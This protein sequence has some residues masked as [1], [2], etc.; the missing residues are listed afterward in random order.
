[1]VWPPRPVAL[2]VEGLF[3]G[4]HVAEDALARRVV[5]VGE[6][7]AAPRILVG[8]DRSRRPFQEDILPL[9]LVAGAAQAGNTPRSQGGGIFFCGPAVGIVAGDT[10]DA[11]PVRLRQHIK[12]EEDGAAGEKGLFKLRLLEANPFRRHPV[13]RG[14]KALRVMTFGAIQQERPGDL[15]M[16]E[17]V[18][19]AVAR[20]LPVVVLPVATPAQTGVVRDVN[21]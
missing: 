8:A 18:T 20:F 9:V 21:G 13:C 1:M 5:G 17:S 4:I 2:G 10:G 3:S 11:F 16:T 19:V 6:T 12:V 15:G 14:N 7:V